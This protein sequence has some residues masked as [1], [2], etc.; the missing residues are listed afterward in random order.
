MIE[1]SEKVVDFKQLV[2]QWKLSDMQYKIIRRISESRRIYKFDSMDQLKFELQLRSNITKA[3]Y[4]LNKSKA[5]FAVFSQS[6]CNHKFWTLTD[7]GGFRLK[8]QVLPSVAIEDIFHHGEKYAF[9]CTMAVI[10]ALY[11]AYLDT[12]PL[13]K[14]NQLFANLLIWAGTYDQDMDLIQL[15]DAEELPGDLSYFKNPD[16]NPKEM[17]WQGENV[18]AM[19]EGTYYGHGIGIAQ[20]KFIIYSL[21]KHRKPG[22]KESAFLS[23]EVTRPDYKR[24]FF[25]DGA[26]TINLRQPP[27]PQNPLQNV[28]T[29][30]VGNTTYVKL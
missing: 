8:D 25:A 15:E 22:A 13:E 14:F 5:D 28:M 21:N 17:E 3:A 6:R 16:V 11:K 9:E 29:I 18:I 2:S 26:Q 27:I 7:K 30:Q 24:V 20:A 12:I 19:G 23:T 10:I 4:D 1:I